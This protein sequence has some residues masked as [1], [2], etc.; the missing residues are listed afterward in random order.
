[1]ET[2]SLQEIKDYPVL[3]RP[4]LVCSGWVETQVGSSLGKAGIRKRSTL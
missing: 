4:E 1:M 2:A 3:V